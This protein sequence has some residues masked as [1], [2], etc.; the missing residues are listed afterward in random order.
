MKEYL[1]A[2]AKGLAPNETETQSLFDE[3]MSG[4]TS[5]VTD[6]QI[7]AYLFSTASRQLS[8]DELVGAARSLREHML[9]VVAPDKAAKILDTCGT[10]GSG[11]KTFNTSTAVALVVAA[12]GQAVAKHGNRAATSPSGSADVLRALGVKLEITPEQARACL[13]A[14]NFCFLFAPQH[15]PATKRV[16]QVRRDLG[17]R[18]IFNFLG[19][20]CNPMFAKYQLLGV[21][22]RSMHAT[23]AEAMLKLGVEH[24]L[25]VRGEDGL[26]EITLAESTVVYEVRR[27]E[28]IEKYTITP[29]K[30]GFARALSSDIEGFAPEESAIKLRQLFIGEKGSHRDLVILNAG[31]ALY[32]S[33]RASSIEEGITLAARALDSGAARK[34]LESVAHFTNVS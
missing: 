23:M 20:L 17:V 12:C 7:G 1:Q 16:Q 30:F 11:L 6:S 31:A 2:L 18:T 8:S 14:T 22:E 24:A 33:H 34:T 3:L 19:P 21:S 25:V 28:G 9:E 32:V 4:D 13:A 5:R 10:G 26:D 27:G 29:E 15:H